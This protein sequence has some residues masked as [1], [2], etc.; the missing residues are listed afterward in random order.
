MLW[1]SLATPG[2]NSFGQQLAQDGAFAGA[3]GAG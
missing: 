3:G 2:F 1:K